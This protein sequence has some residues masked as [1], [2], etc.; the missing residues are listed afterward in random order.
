MTR[1]ERKVS[2][3]RVVN[4][5]DLRRIAQ[6]RLPRV[7]FDY[8]DGGAL[9]EVTLRENT[10]AF[11]DV[12]FRPRNA[13][14]IPERDTRTSVL[15]SELSMPM[16]LAP[17][18]FSH[19]FYPHGEPAAARAAGKAGIGYVLT[20]MSGHR[21]EEVAEATS[22]PRWYQLY[23]A[24][25]HD[26]GKGAIERAQKA[27]F[28]ALVI[29]IDTGTFGMRERDVRNGAG[30]LLGSNLHAKIPFLPQVLAHPGWLAGFL[31]SGGM[32]KLHNIVV[33][34]RGTLPLSEAQ[35]SL[36]KSVVTWDDLKW[37]RKEWPGPIVV[38]GVMIAEDAKRAV[39]EGAAGVVVSNHG[40]RQLDGVA[41]TLRALPEIVAAVG[42][43]TEVLF[44][45]GIR[46]GSDIAK[47]LCLGARAVLVGRAYMYGLGAAGEAGVARAIDILRADLERVMAL[48]GC[49]SLAELSRSYVDVPAGWCV[50]PRS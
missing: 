5:A 17:C 15:G 3:P 41:S 23:L 7:L 19:M 37:I 24:G 8:L 31:R 12:T 25:G 46:R 42:G 10:R 48:L 35:S 32:R 39:D 4:V 18:G 26:A 50:Q 49:K 11:E 27:G 2:S 44:D 30:A 13:L 22:G 45:G 6:H 47:A 33:P 20:T 38:K 28:S 1:E 40:G 9:G 21:L 34:G 43:R 16:L 36:G 14:Y 29:T